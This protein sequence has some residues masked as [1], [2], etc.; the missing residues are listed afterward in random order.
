MKKENSKVLAFIMVCLFVASS[1][2]VETFTNNKTVVTENDGDENSSSTYSVSVIKTGAGSGTVLYRVIA[3]NND[4]N[5]D[6]GDINEDEENPDGDEENP[7]Y[8]EENPDGDEENPDGD[9]E[10]P[11]GDEDDSNGDSNE[12]NIEYT[13]FTAGEFKEG[14]VIELKFETDESSFLS[15]VLEGGDDITANVRDNNCVY[16]F[17]VISDCVYTANYDKVAP[18]QDVD[19]FFEGTP[20]L[21]DIVYSNGIKGR[22]INSESKQSLVVSPNTCVTL[23]P[24][25]SNTGAKINVFYSDQ[26]YLMWWIWLDAKYEKNI[27]VDTEKKIKA[28]ILYDGEWKICANKPLMSFIPDGDAP[29]V[30]ITPEGN[31]SNPVF[32]K[33][34]NFSIDASDELAGISN[35][36]YYVTY[37]DDDEII[38]GCRYDE[39][40]SEY[41]GDEQ[42]G[43]LYDEDENED[44]RLSFRK[45]NINVPIDSENDN[46]EK[47][48]IH[49]VAIDKFGN[50]E[51]YT[52]SV[53]INT[54]P[55]E[56]MIE[57]DE[58]E[59]LVENYY[60]E[61]RTA[62][63]TI[64][65]K[66]YSFDENSVKDY[67]KKN[68]VKV[69]HDSVGGYLNSRSYNYLCD[70]DFEDDSEDSKYKICSATIL[71]PVESDAA[72][73]C[74]AEGTILWD[75]CGSASKSGLISHV[76]VQNSECIDNYSNDEI[77][78]DY[79]END[80]FVN[81]ESDNAREWE[82]TLFFYIDSKTPLGNIR[83]NNGC[84]W[85][86]LQE[87]AS[88][89]TFF[90]ENIHFSVWMTEYIEAD[91]AISVEYYTKEYAM[92]DVME[93]VNVDNEECGE[94][95]SVGELDELYE[96]DEFKEGPC[97]I[98][99]NGA[100]VVYARLTDQNQNCRYVSTEGFILDKTGSKIQI[101]LEG[102]GD[103]NN[104]CFKGNVIAKIM[105]SEDA[106]VYSGIDS[107]SYAIFH[108]QQDDD[109]LIKSDELRQFDLN[110]NKDISLDVTLNASECD[111][112]DLIFVVYV[113]DK[114]AN[115]TYCQRDVSIDT[116][117]PVVTVAYDNN[118]VLNDKYFNTE[119]TATIK[120]KD[121]N[122]DASKSLISVANSLNEN[123]II[124][125][126]NK[127]GESEG[128]TIY[129]ATV[130]FSGDGDYTLSIDVSDKAG[131]KG[132]VSFSEGTRCGTTFTID[133]TKPVV[134]VVYSNN[135]VQN[136]IFFKDSRTAIIT[137]KEKNWDEKK[138]ECNKT[139]T[140][141][142]KPVKVPILSWTNNGDTHVGTILFDDDGDY[143][144]DIS[145]TDLAENKSDDVNYGNSSA[146]QRFTIDKTIEEA[147]ITGVKDAHAYSG[148]FSFT[149]DY[150]DI[151]YFSSKVV[152]KRIENNKSPE[153]ITSR[154]VNVKKGINGVI[155]S[156]DN[157]EKILENDGIYKLEFVGTDKAGNETTTELSFT[158]NRFGSIFVY[159]EYLGVINSQYL[160]SLQDDVKLTEYNSCQLVSGSTN[161]DITC[162]GEHLS[163]VIYEVSP[164]INE[165]VA[166]GSS[167]WYQYE[168][169]ISKDNFAKDGVYR[170]TVSSKDTAGNYSET[171]DFSD[172]GIIF[173]VDTT[174]PEI[175]SIMG[176]DNNIINANTVSVEFEVFDAI[177]VKRIE[178][179]DDN[180]LIAQFENFE[181]P[182]F[183][184][185]KFELSSGTDKSLRMVVE[186]KAGN[187]I[188]T[189]NYSVEK[190]GPNSPM[191]VMNRKITIS[192]NFFVRL[193]ANKVAFAMSVAGTSA[194][195]LGIIG[196]CLRKRIALAVRLLRGKV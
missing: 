77:I 105:V 187:I 24:E 46:L 39:V 83:T 44:I 184:S 135:S 64:R 128:N 56:V 192:T 47:V 155:Y 89:S 90:N 65:D 4:E 145:V 157:F 162:D 125:G 50:E 140:L 23:K 107:V 59:S 168:Y 19:A 158:I 136:D 177:G 70:L 124:S 111:M 54:V 92:S 150:N 15:C 127:G 72:S 48:V 106:G 10:N 170:I 119:R 110:Y 179:F 131:N 191:E 101:E 149:L 112:N 134:S 180:N 5:Q 156:F 194:L 123:A 61:T 87:Y 161:V 85:N 181:N 98:T 114:A 144:F 63:I 159:G 16:Q 96:Q 3:E 68:I 120:V 22:V 176:L 6:N 186:D 76:S 79:R 146:P 45:E 102:D 109:H 86:G 14:T 178:V 33:D 80:I 189:S 82:R 100:Y 38:K 53:S 88:F 147:T 172:E 1:L 30:T 11:D 32:A 35:L 62:T 25:N 126:W 174:A 175:T 73:G 7:N 116:V 21:F 41:E 183:I 31:Q 132:D 13:V 55:A 108:L 118:N 69:E 78:D 93:I 95:L 20:G 122:F 182:L 28:V 51:E 139:A 188:D 40:L 151:N 152:L 60:N 94:L 18:V 84:S 130:K 52:K 104:G 37:N 165:S 141:N 163:N 129:Y 121:R 97:N 148:D 154:F 27:L 8:D 74:D 43:M 190:Y 167:G 166:L 91:E 26:D 160:Q 9:E 193:Y 57:F 49:V 169:T 36:Y 29:S 171:S 42:E 195:C 185:D 67:L 71:F 173:F 81:D 17:T 143:T 196:F 142:G 137:V 138:V 115:F 66:A 117:K 34:F 12:N 2:M 164:E 103:K 153:E 113:R 58:T 99:E 133:K 75:L